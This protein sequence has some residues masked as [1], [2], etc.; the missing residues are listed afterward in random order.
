MFLGRVSGTVTSTV[1]HPFYEGRRLLLVDR[2]DTALEP[3]GKYVIAIDTVEAGPGNLVLLID[4]GNSARQVL[5]D[6]SAPVRAVIV[7]VVDEV[8]IAVK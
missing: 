6:S 1:N 3:D 5:G 4:E 2:L 7:G 8:D